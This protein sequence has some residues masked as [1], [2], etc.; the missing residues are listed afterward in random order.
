[1]L[2]S[3]LTGI[4][5]ANTASS[6]AAGAGNLD[7]DI[8]PTGPRLW[9]VQYAVG[10]HVS[11]GART[12]GWYWYCDSTLNYICRP[13]SMNDYSVL[14]WDG[15]TAGVKGFAHVPAVVSADRFLRFRVTATGAGD[16]AY[17]RYSYLEI[18]GTYGF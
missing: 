17:L 6:T 8:Q 16:T 1:M 2:D 15:Y 14:P 13:T 10:Y 9:I 18:L 5:R 3:L 7:L 12:Q 4:Q 11:G